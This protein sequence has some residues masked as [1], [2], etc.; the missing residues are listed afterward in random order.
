MRS[1]KSILAGLAAGALG[2]AL[3]P[4]IAASPAQATVSTLTVSVPG[5]A[6][7]KPLVSDDSI[8]RLVPIQVTL[9]DSNG[10]KINLT[11][12]ETL[13]ATVTTPAGAVGTNAT[14]FGL[15]DD[16]T[17]PASAGFSLVSLARNGAGTNTGEYQIYL[18]PKTGGTVDEWNAGAGGVPTGTY[19]VNI[20]YTNNDTGATQSRDVKVQVLD[21]AARPTA[22]IAWVSNAAA[23]S[24]INAVSAVEEGLAVTQYAALVNGSGYP[25]IGLANI[26]SGS[27][28]TSTTGPVTTVTTSSGF[29]GN[30]VNDQMTAAPGVYGFDPTGANWLAAASSA[31]NLSYNAGAQTSSLPVTFGELTGGS[32]ATVTATLTT[33]PNNLPSLTPEVPAGTTTLSFLITTDDTMSGTWAW[34]ASAAGGGEITP[35]AGVASVSNN[36]ALVTVSLNAAAAAAGNVITLTGGVA[37][38]GALAGYS[39]TQS[40][41]TPYLDVPANQIAKIGDAVAVE[42]TLTDQFGRPLT[43]TWLVSV[44]KNGTATVLG[45]TNT[46][47]DGSFTLTVPAAASPTA[48]G[49][50]Q[51][52]FTA[53]NGT[54]TATGNTVVT[55]NATGG[56]TSLTV[57]TSPV[58]VGGR[59]PAVLVPGTGTAALT[60]NTTAVVDPSAPGSTIPAGIQNSAEMTATVVP[61]T[62]ITVTAPEGVYLARTTT[63]NVNWNAGV[64]TLNVPTGTPISVWST[65]VGAQTITF[66]AGDKTA[67][68]QVFA[69]TSPDFARNI[70]LD[71]E[72]VTIAPNTFTSIVATVSDVFGNS[73]AGVTSANLGVAL[74]GGG[75]ISP[76]TVSTTGAAGTTTV[77]YTAPTAAGSAQVT[78]TGT[79]AQFATTITGAPAAKATA[80]TEITVSGSVPTDKSI[81]IVGERGTVSGKSGILVDGDTTGFD[82]GAKMKPWIRFPGESSY[83]VGSAR[84]EVSAAGDFSWQRK[85][86]KKVYVFFTSEDDAIKSNRI[87]IDAK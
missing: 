1:S 79:G 25:I 18:N 60:T 50:V 33:T 5:V 84:P 66:K 4:F 68:A 27:T 85:T 69:F 62:T 53:T 46:A 87:I 47:A 86:G 55:Y 26:V 56:V 39:V 65:K 59:V 74:A 31:Y 16:S 12:A 64:Q 23:T 37:G 71:K 76:T 54:D 81:L 8:Q 15:S 51:Y 49:N 43:G 58:T 11:S 19:N 30:G 24:V 28:A 41:A 73:L 3:I 52:D 44:V 20:L 32:A 34:A 36:Q 38:S 13:Q 7:V 40:L 21:N 72:K 10:A 70:T 78:F 82:R 22:G 6:I 9:R 83:N 2:A 77:A 48:A 42:G 61:S 17:A 35:S 45:S 80:R 67:T 14:S 29:V 57:A 63:S 75:T